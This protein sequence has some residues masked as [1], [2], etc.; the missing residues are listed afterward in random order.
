M[1]RFILT[2]AL[3]MAFF[4]GFSQFYA[5]NLKSNKNSSQIHCNDFEK[6]NMSFSYDGISSFNVKTVKGEFSEI[7]I[8]GTYPIGEVGTPKLPATKKLLSIPFG[9]ETS[10]KVIN[11]EKETYKLLDYGITHKL[12]PNQPS[13]S[14]SQ[15]IE[16]IPFAYK[17]E[18][19]ARNAYSTHE[20]AT[21]EV[22][23]VMRGVR[24]ARLEVAPIRYNPMTDEI[25][26]YN[27]IEV[28]VTFKNSNEAKTKAIRASTY[29]PYFNLPYGKLFNWNTGKDSGDGYPEH[30]DLTKH[31]IKY[32]VVS[33]RMF[34]STLQPFLTWKTQ[35]G[36]ELIVAYTDEIGSSYNEIKTWIHDQY[37]NAD[38]VKPSFLLL[39]GDSPQIPMKM[40]SASQ[41]Y[42]DLY[43]GS[44][45]GDQFPEMYYARFSAENVADL[46][47]QIDKTL[48]YEKYQFQDPAYLDHVT[49][50]AGQDNTWNP[51]VG[52]ATVHY[53]VDNYFNTA[54]G[55]STVNAY[56]DSYSGCYSTINDG[57]GFINYTAHC[58]ET[59]WSG[60]AFTINDVN[61]LANQNMYPLVV[62]N[63]CLSNNIGH[64]NECIGETWM[65]KANGGAVAYIGSAPSSYWYEDFYWSVGA[66]PIQ[67]TNN[68]YVPTTEETTMGAYDAMFLGDYECV[69]AK[70]FVGNLAVTEAHLQNYQHSSTLTPLYYWQAYMCNGDPSLMIYHTQGTENSVSHLPSLVVGID[71]YQVSADPGSYVGISKDG[72]LLGSALVGESGS[73]DVNITPITSSGNV[74]IVVTGRQKIP[75]ITQVPATVLDGPYLIL[76]GFTINDNNNQVIESGESFSMDINIENIGPE[77]ANDVNATVEGADNYFTIIQNS[78]AV[79]AVNP[80]QIVTVNDAFSFALANNV[81]DQHQATFDMVMTD[82][83]NETWTSKLK[84]TANAPAME[85]GMV[86]VIA[87][88]PGCNN[89]LDV[90]QDEGINIHILNNGHADAHNVTTSLANVSNNVSIETAE[91]TLGDIAAEGQTE[92]TYNVSVSGSANV[93]DIA[94]F[95]LTITTGGYTVIKTFE[96]PIGLITENFESSFVL[97]D[98]Q[99]G[100]NADWTIT[101]DE[102]HEGACSAQSGA[103]DNAQTSTMYMHGNVLS[104]S[105]ISF[106]YKVSSEPNYDKLI[107]YI[108]DIEKASWSGEVDWTLAE[109]PVEPGAHTFTW[110]Y[111]KDVT[112]SLGADKAWIDDIT[113]PSMIVPEGPLT[114]NIVISNNPVCAGASFNLSANVSGGSGNYTYLWSP[115][116]AV[117]NPN[118]QSTMA[119]IDETTTF[120][121]QISDG[122]DTIESTITVTALP[123]PAQPEIHV[124]ALNTLMATEAAGYQWLRITAEPIEGANEQT[125]VIP[126]SGLY[127]VIVQN[128]KDCWSIPAQPFHATINVEDTVTDYAN[129]YPNPFSHKATIEYV[130]RTASDLKIMVV[131]SLGKVVKVLENSSM[132]DAGIH[133][134]DINGNDLEEGVYFVVFQQNN[135]QFTKKLVLVK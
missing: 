49:L 69:D 46:Q 67:G 78:T 31:P 36:Y 41:K 44:V 93:G 120:T 111:K 39:V 83:A 104:P 132:K 6:I 34:E 125:F 75:Y 118:A 7:S 87:E 60:P 28:E 72:V 21:I 115:A 81:P 19:Y 63:C 80:E 55:Y 24:I 85:I 16:D 25:T 92:V 51:R 1:K 89:N 71:T 126:A 38:G 20:L 107:F 129:I 70:I 30:P 47:P 37:N 17:A 109:F 102:S 123:R 116:T 3:L 54:H 15:D 90:G 4:C 27:N 96:L 100:G 74:D 64:N 42:T 130:L 26:V 33:D 45:D 99:F 23:G 97:L 10:V 108:D 98:W 135:T 14:K 8:P 121:V 131:N 61:N 94:S 124:S 133:T 58:A 105:N 113:F 73:V 101:S 110:E 48:Y 12:M 13:I 119:T 134:Y 122:T 65:R 68:G 86:T 50:I 112:A 82:N 76:D 95:E 62:A 40:G 91:L 59:S 66:F 106:Y 117:S 9:A 22:L 35:Q 53:G 84:L 56:Y 103:I 43:Y 29:S 11:F 32:L 114:T 77:T 18:A 2:F 128:E 127:T 57:L 5:I 88:A 79:G 52:Q